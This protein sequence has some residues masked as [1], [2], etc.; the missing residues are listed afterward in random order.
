MKSQHGDCA[1]MRDQ[2]VKTQLELWDFLFASQLFDLAANFLQKGLLT[3][4]KVDK[5]VHFKV[6]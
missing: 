2:V 1:A 6:Y 5:V 3:D 4:C